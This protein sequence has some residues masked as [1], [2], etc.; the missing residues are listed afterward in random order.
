MNDIQPFRHYDGSPLLPGGEQAFRV[1]LVDPRP[2]MAATATSNRDT[3]HGKPPDSL[4]V[5]SVQVDRHGDLF[6][7]EVTIVVFDPGVAGAMMIFDPATGD[8]RTIRT[9]EQADFAEIFGARPLVW[10]PAV[11]P[12]KH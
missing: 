9:H 11:R 12:E 5:R 6:E 4:F 2:V 7:A 1:T 10:L 8:L 3:W